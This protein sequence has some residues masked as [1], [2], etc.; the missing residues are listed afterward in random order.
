MFNVAKICSIEAVFG[1]LFKKTE[2]QS[3]DQISSGER[4]T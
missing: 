3:L 4:K 2:K 1:E